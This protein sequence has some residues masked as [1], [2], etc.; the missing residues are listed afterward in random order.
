MSDILAIDQIQKAKIPLQKEDFEYAILENASLD[1]GTFEKKPFIGVDIDDELC[2]KY[3]PELEPPSI[4]QSDTSVTLG[5]QDIGS[6][7]L[8]QSVRKKKSKKSGR[9]SKVQKMEDCAQE[10]PG[11]PQYAQSREGSNP[12]RRR[13][14]GKSRLQSDEQPLSYSPDKLCGAVS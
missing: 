6:D 11:M 7:S 1:T 3:C 14:G 8:D 9:K 13:S 5:S 10:I 2:I 4:C 12:H